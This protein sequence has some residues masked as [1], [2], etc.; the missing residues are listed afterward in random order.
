MAQLYN[1]SEYI[2]W[3]RATQ[4][5]GILPDGETTSGWV[6]IHGEISTIY[7]SA[8]RFIF[9]IWHGGIHPSPSNIDS[10]ICVDDLMFGKI[11]K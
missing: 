1:G 2:G 9:G 8:N 5:I 11:V 10:T 7:P 4:L 6:F 3:A